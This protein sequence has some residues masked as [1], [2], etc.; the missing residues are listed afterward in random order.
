MR[1]VFRAFTD[2]A[3]AQRCL[4]AVWE[5]LLLPQLDRGGASAARGFSAL[6]WMTK[7]LAMRGHPRVQECLLSVLR[8]LSGSGSPAPAH[9]ASPVP[10]SAAPDTT[11]IAASLGADSESGAPASLHVVEPPAIRGKN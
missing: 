10:L 3:V 8:L 1:F 9:V 4:G 5:E 2:E 6:G 11:A 7:A